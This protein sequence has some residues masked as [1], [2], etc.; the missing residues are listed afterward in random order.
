[1]TATVT[2]PAPAEP[3][4]E[5][6][7]LPAAGHRVVAIGSGLGALTATKALKP[8]LIKIIDVVVFLT[9]VAAQCT[10]HLHKQTWLWLQVVPTAAAVFAIIGVLIT[11]RILFGAGRRRNEMTTA[12]AYF[13]GEGHQRRSERTR[14]GWH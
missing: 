6:A 10:S 4:L 14:K 2:L 1:M 5:S 13:S 7:L 9:R 12:A 8:E 11:L 3:Y